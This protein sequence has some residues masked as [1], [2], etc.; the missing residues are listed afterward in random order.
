MSEEETYRLHNEV[1]IHR[2]L[3]R[4]LPDQHPNI[5][6][7]KESFLD[8][9]VFGCIVLE[10]CK[11]GDLLSK[12]NIARKKKQVLPEEQ[13]LGWL[14]QI[15]GAVQYIHSQRVLHRDLKLANCFITSGGVVKV[16]DYG[17]A[18]QLPE[19]CEMAEEK[20]GTITAMAP[21]LVAH[22]YATYKSDVWALGSLIY[23]L[24]TH[25]PVYEVPFDSFGLDIHRYK[26]AMSRPFKPIP[27]HYSRG[28]RGVTEAMLA[29]EADD[30]PLTEQLLTMLDEESW[31]A[32]APEPTE[33]VEKSRIARIGSKVDCG[34]PAGSAGPRRG[35][36]PKGGPAQ[37]QRGGSA[38]D[39]SAKPASARGVAAAAA[40][41]REGKGKGEGE[42][43]SAWTG[44]L[45]PRAKQKH[46]SEQPRSAREQAQAR[47][48]K[49]FRQ[50]AAAASAVGETPRFGRRAT[51]G[52]GD[53]SGRA[54]SSSRRRRA[55]A[56]LLEDPPTPEAAKAG[57][58]P[59]SATVPRSPRQASAESSGAPPATL[60][61]ARQRADLA[62]K[63]I[64]VAKTSKVRKE[65][66]PV[67]GQEVECFFEAGELS[68][69]R[70][71]SVDKTEGA[72]LWVKCRGV[73]TL[74]PF[75]RALDRNSLWRPLPPTAAA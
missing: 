75:H 15:V 18:C 36:I 63:K 59:N 57:R 34:R 48:E 8:R 61:A 71:G 31:P 22:G 16:G 29:A 25:G 41:A 67:M 39:R 74:G 53:E 56:E 26:A 44:A 68:Q 64:G 52:S 37:R 21:E 43:G 55:S 17:L 69:W 62:V 32:N 40:A 3:H 47:Q 60:A 73:G 14:R 10:Y 2:S 11:G 70:P 42:G 66:R 7:F 38:S 1:H 27:E 65:F 19:G 46:G 4:G 33:R 30:R 45:A 72:K 6:Q 28:L 54:A 49:R 9:K 20:V 23:Q 5:V 50:K 58:R 51:N 12:L 13:C 24:A 35:G